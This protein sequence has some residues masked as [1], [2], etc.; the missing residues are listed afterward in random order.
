MEGG[1][2]M[3]LI[4]FDRCACRAAGASVRGTVDGSMLSSTFV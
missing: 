3:F 2:E 1:I 4:Y